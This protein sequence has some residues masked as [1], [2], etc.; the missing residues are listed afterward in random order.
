MS[1]TERRMADCH[2][3]RKH[4][5]KGLCQQCY[6]K[7]N[8]S[9]DYVTQKFGDRLPDYRR[10]Y[11][12]SSKSRERASRY[13]HVRTAIAKLLDRPEPKMREVFSD[14]VAIATLRAALDRGDPILTKVWSDLTKKQKKAIYGQLDE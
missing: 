9:T 13:Y 7:E 3:T 4:Y 8:F 5:A 14:P 2:P 1:I 6:R 12:E 11:E 10:K